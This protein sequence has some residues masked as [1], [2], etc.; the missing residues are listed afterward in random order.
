VRRDLDHGV[1]QAAALAGQENSEPR[2]QPGTGP[3][4]ERLVVGQP[5]EDGGQAGFVG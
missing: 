4:V 3:A 1:D 5:G 2:N